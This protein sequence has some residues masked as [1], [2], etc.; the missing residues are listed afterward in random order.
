MREK[1]IVW[2]ITSLILASG[3]LGACSG[4]GSEELRASGVVEAVEVIVAPELGGRIVEIF[5]DE[6]D[7]VRE[8]DALFRVDDELLVGQIA[9]AE[10]AFRAALASQEA[11]QSMLDSADAGLSA[12]S[13]GVEL[14]TVQY[15]MELAV[16]R[17]QDS[18]ARTQVWAQVFPYSFD[19]PAWYFEQSEYLAGAEAEIDAAEDMLADEREN[20][21]SVLQETDS[22]DLIAAEKRLLEAQ[23]AFEVA[24]ELWQRRISSVKQ[25]YMDDFIDELYDDAK[26]E[27]E[28][29]QDDYDALLDDDAA[30][31]VLEARARL[32]VAVERLETA[33]D[34]R[35]QLLVG[36]ESLR[37]QVAQAGILQAEAA[38]VAATATIEQAQV[39]VDQ[40]DAVVA[41]TQAAL[42]L[43]E[44]QLDK[45][46]VRAAVTGVL[47]TRSV[48]PGEVVVPGMT[49]MTIGQLDRLSIT[50][51]LPEDRYGQ[52][53]V[54]DGAE[55]SVDSFPDETFTAVVVR[56]ADQ[57]EYTPRNVQ[58]EEDRRTTVY[59]VELT[60]DDPGDSLKPGMPA[61]VVFNVEEE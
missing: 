22:E 3:L 43:L 58:T 52:I 26:D 4:D 1:R 8:G 9:Q 18:P 28:A 14:A 17:A 20:Y 6:G 51:Y 15:E 5:V 46:T 25:S 50:V 60:V 49:L 53:S 59:A 37:V 35:D 11:T 34:Q 29:A 12:A 7:S 33:L 41:Q 54:G 55:V 13:A 23:A 30:D 27:L 57:A 47:M 16:S 36:R 38:E 10:A 48:E 19:L 21:E 24:K 32:A 39:A 42:D 2:L 56:I 45:L 31:D 44:V 40:A 61:D